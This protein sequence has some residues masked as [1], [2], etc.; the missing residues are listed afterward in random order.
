MKEQLQAT[1]LQILFHSNEGN[2]LENHEMTDKSSTSSTPNHLK[3]YLSLRYSILEEEYE[4]VYT[5]LAFTEHCGIT[6]GIDELTICFLVNDNN[7]SDLIENDLLNNFSKHL[8]KF[9]LLKKE[10]IIEKNWNQEWED[11][12]EPIHIND[13]IVV[14][15]SWKAETVQA[16]IVLVINPQMSFGSG[17]H[18]TTRMMAEFIQECVAQ[19]SVWIDAGTGTGLLAIL[20][21]QCGAKSVF[22]FDNDEWSVLNT[23]ENVERN[24]IPRECIRVEQADVFTVPLPFS[25]GIA[26]NLH[27]NLIKPNL[28]RFYDAL[29]SQ[30]RTPAHLL[31]SGIL[32]YD[33]DDVLEEA[34]KAGF[35]HKE[36]KQ[37]GDWIALHCTKELPPPPPR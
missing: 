2:P 5:A 22:A 32:R 15:P 8:I 6:E 26:A 24:P 35:Q 16:P 19:D 34:L 3:T 36:T 23:K 30:H 25:N 20:A 7:I 31:L 11:S 12:I 28:S 14:T 13:S 18:E 1:N 27:K 4:K 17:H 21:V 29:S 10:V 33:A 37:Q 9:S